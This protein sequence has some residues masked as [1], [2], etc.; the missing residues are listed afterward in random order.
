MN[1]SILSSEID[2]HIKIDEIIIYQLE[3][4]DRNRFN[5]HAWRCGL[6][7]NSFTMNKSC[8]FVLIPKKSLF[9]GSVILDQQ[10][11]ENFILFEAS[12]K[13]TTINYYRKV[14]CEVDFMK[15]GFL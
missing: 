5:N 14:Y 9:K 3:K 8:V 6:K 15:R 1:T 12:I 13:K 7:L 4:K 2:F 10:N 11:V